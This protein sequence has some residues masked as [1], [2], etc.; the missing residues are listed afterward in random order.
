MTV[1]LYKI[2]SKYYY[3][4][5]N[6]FDHICRFMTN[7]EIIFCR[8]YHNVKIDQLQ[9]IP[10]QVDNFLSKLYSLFFRNSSR[11]QKKNYKLNS[12]DGKEVEAENIFKCIEEV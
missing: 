2:S 10:N 12:H 3:Q 5:T 7:K 6:L 9:I 8:Q 4:C 11:Y 1:F